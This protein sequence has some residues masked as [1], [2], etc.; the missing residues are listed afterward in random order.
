MG[1]YALVVDRMGNEIRV[2]FREGRVVAEGALS[3]TLE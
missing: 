3:I 2:Y 1:D